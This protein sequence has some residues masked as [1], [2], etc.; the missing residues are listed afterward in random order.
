MR[1]QMSV[2]IVTN[3]SAAS[4]SRHAARSSQ[5]SEASPP[6]ASAISAP[7][8]GQDIDEEEQAGE[9]EQRAPAVGADVRVEPVGGH[10]GS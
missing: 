5:S 3:G 6:S 2:P 7:G 4:R 9:Q 10:G 8:K 1:I